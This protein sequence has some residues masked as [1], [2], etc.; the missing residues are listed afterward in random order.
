MPEN[1]VLPGHYP[2][3]TGEKSGFA[4]KQ[5]KP[6]KNPLPP[7]GMAARPIELITFRGG[8]GPFYSN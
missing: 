5:N 3:H 7:N 4:S 1:A 2:T 6:E 8:M